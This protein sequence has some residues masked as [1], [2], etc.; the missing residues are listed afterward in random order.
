MY[1]PLGV[2]GVDKFPAI[3]VDRHLNQHLFGK[4]LLNRDNISHH[5]SWHHVQKIL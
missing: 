2:R 5:A 3:L 4:H 1:L